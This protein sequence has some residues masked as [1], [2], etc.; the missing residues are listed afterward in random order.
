MIYPSHCKYVGI[1]KLDNDLNVEEIYFLTEYMILTRNPYD[2][3]ENDPA[4]ILR[5]DVERDEGMMGRARSVEVLADVDETLVVE[6]SDIDVMNPNDLVPFAWKVSGEGEKK[7]VVVRGAG[8]H[9][10]FAV[11]D[12]PPDIRTIRVVD[13]FPDGRLSLMVRNALKLGLID[14]D[15]IIQVEEDVLNLLEVAEEVDEKVE[16]I[17][18]PCRMDVP[19]EI[20]GRKTWFADRDIPFSSIV[21]IGCDISRR[22]VEERFS[23][24]VIFRNMCPLKRAKGTF[25]AR[26][27]KSGNT[28]RRGNGYVVHWGAGM[29]DVVGAL[30]DLLGSLE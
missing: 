27:C 12:T 23:G 4:M 14:S 10:N 5:V 1:G 22:I 7:G 20:N 15:E 26:C 25:I 2:I 11:F 30:N 13:T 3:R 16:A 24:K 19:E 8:D 17:V 6:N 18:F 21:L 28:G 29:R 9:V